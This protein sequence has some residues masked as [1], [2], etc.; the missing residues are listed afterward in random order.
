MFR[1]EVIYTDE[2][3][4]WFEALEESEQDAVIVVTRMLGQMGVTLGFPASSA[5][6]GSRYAL[7]ELRPKQGR[8]PLRVIYAFDPDRDAVLLIGGD[9]SSNAKFYDRI[10]RTAEAVWEAYLAALTAEK[11]AE[12]KKK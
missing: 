1:V 6:K 4:K 8:S 7:R 3:G 9:K 11:K 5:L 12:E 2:F 10:I